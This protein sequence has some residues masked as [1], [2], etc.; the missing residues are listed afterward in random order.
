M[1]PL[2]CVSFDPKTPKIRTCSLLLVL[3][4]LFNRSFASSWL[5][6]LE[7]LQLFFNNPLVSV[8]FCFLHRTS[9]SCSA[10]GQS[11]WK[12]LEHSASFRNF[13]LFTNF[14]FRFVLQFGMNSWYQWCISS[15]IPFCS[16]NNKLIYRTTHAVQ[17]CTWSNFG[18]I[19]LEPFLPL[20]TYPYT[21][22]K[23][24]LSSYF[25][26]LP[27]RGAKAFLL[28][29]MRA[30]SKIRTLYSHKCTSNRAFRPLASHTVYQ[31]DINSNGQHLCLRFA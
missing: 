31:T 19:Q 21:C 3:S 1:G 24:E 5:R 2:L 28:I 23:F 4:S 8:L 25:Y 12:P 10:S 27:V 13:H 17:S 29:D 7:S 18:Q 30:H 16:K 20:R 22:K 26:S 6:N 9:F 14:F 15:Q 11:D